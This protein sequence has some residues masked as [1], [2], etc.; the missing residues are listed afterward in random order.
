[1]SLVAFRYPWCCKCNNS[2]PIRSSEFDA[3]ER[4]GETFYCHSGHAIVVTQDSIVSQLRTS[5]RRLWRSEAERDGLHKQLECT[6][7]VITRQRNRLVHGKCPYCGKNVA[8]I[9][10]RSMLRH[11]RENHGK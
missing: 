7:G 4:S 10:E 1:M 6:R 2:F 3:L 11:I 5:E 8:E 9:E